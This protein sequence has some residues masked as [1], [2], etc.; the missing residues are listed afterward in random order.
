MFRCPWSG[1]NI[2]MLDYHDTEWGVP[3][4][5]DRMLLE[6]LILDGAQAGLSWMTILK[7]RDGYRR[8]FDEFDPRL[9]AAYD[10]SKVAS[11][12][13]DASIIR[14]R[15]KIRSAIA[16]AQA[17]LRLQEEFGSFDRYIWQ[18][19]GG[20]PIRNRRKSLTDIP[21][22]TP[23]SDAMS[24]DLK[25]RGF[26]FVGTTICYAFMQAVGMVDDHVVACFRYGLKT[27]RRSR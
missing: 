10:E 22:T 20:E 9:I 17:F 5:D 15:Q 3:R 4:H 19:V 7:K 25:K 6:Y 27:R 1:D 8:A 2:L 26:K 14:N 18:F 11:L 24:K 12:L 13:Q 23:E 21:A 16:N